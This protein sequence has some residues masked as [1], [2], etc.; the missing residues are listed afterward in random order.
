[1]LQSMGSQRVRHTG[2]T[3]QQ[4]FSESQ[5]VFLNMN[6]WQFMVSEI[7]RYFYMIKVEVEGWVGFLDRQNVLDN[8]GCSN[9]IS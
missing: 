1:M 8:V 4:E 2:A 9:R 5:Y 7:I 3:E 6:L